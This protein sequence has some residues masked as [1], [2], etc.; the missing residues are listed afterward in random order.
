[1]RPLE[2]R[3][4]NFRSYFGDEQVF[5]FRRRRLVGVVGPIGSGKSSLLDA[6]AFALYGKT[7]TVARGTTALI[8]QRA[9]E[10]AV[11]LRFEVEGEVWEAVRLLRRKGASQH[12]L[13]RYEAD[14]PDAE[15]VETVTQEGAVNGRVVELLGLEFDAFCRSVMLAQGRFAEFLRSPPRERDKVLKGVFG[16]DRIDRMREVAKEWAAAADI[17]I[18]KLA[19]RVDELGRVAARITEHREAIAGAEQRLG[20]LRRIEPR[21]GALGEDL[22]AATEEVKRCEQRLTELRL[23]RKRFPEPEVTARLLATAAEASERRQALADSLEE[24]Q[25]RAAEADA[26]IAE[27]EES[28]IQ[29]TLSRGHSLLASIEAQQKPV[30]AAAQRLQALQTRATEIE[31]ERAAVQDR[32]AAARIA[33]EGI[34]KQAAATADALSAAQAALHAAELA[35]MAEVLRAGLTVGEPCPVCTQEVGVVPPA[36]AAGDLDSAEAAVERA[37]RDQDHVVRERTSAAAEAQG[38]AER[39]E[40]IQGAA[41]GMEAEVSAAAAERERAEE[42][43]AVTVAEFRELLGEGD[44]ATMLEARREAYQ[45][46]KEAAGEAR[47]GVGR[48][49]GEHEQAIRDGH[50]V[51]KAMD[52]LRVELA[53]MAARLDVSLEMKDDSAAA[54]GAAL[55]W[56]QDRWKETITELEQGRDAAGRRTDD[57]A[58]ARSELLADHDVEGDYAASMAEVRA[59]LELWTKELGRDEAE[60]A[61][62]DELMASRDALASEHD[63]FRRIAADLTD[64]RFVRFLLDEERAHLAE[65][66]SDH[67][68]RLSAGRYRFSEDGVFDIVDLTAADATRRADSL[69]GGETFIAS[70]ALALA[71]AEMVARTGGRLDSF[72]LDEGFGVLDPE[73]LDLAME[74]IEALVADS[75]ER[76]VVVVSHVPEMHQRMEDLIEL[77]RDP[78]T[79]DTKVISA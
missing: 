48:I 47:K 40:S 33:L 59:Q 10:G 75:D 66:G 41:T 57:A 2:L 63:R 21:L 53:E 76:L 13:Y 3:V 9:S 14:E 5:D 67:F 70:L 52:H 44:P 28:G 68:Q 32:L 24:A 12:A 34:E 62:S 54:A 51:E 16:H 64:S 15:P 78:A 56:L 36:A 46:V 79:G 77:D 37:R 69:S 1:M 72:F 27:F 35:N 4:R 20:D 65:L 73:H 11:S 7:P 29:G 60:V 50:G 19:V 26:R 61:A 25:A 43:L 8:H 55:E 74:G 71:L 45:V 23:L 18:A 42:A 58:K 39:L 30:D 6:V 31:V 17:E 22:A 38:A 49:R